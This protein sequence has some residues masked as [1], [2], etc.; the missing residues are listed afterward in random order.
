M[1]RLGL[2]FFAAS[3]VVLGVPSALVVEAQVPPPAY[4]CCSQAGACRLAYPLPPG[5]PC[6]C[7]TYYGPVPGAACYP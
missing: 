4:S 3:F 6:Y 7:A 2:M 5:Y 1:R